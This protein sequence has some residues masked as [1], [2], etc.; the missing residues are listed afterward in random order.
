VLVLDAPVTL[1]KGGLAVS[2]GGH[3]IPAGSKGNVPALDVN[4]I[5]CFPN[6]ITGSA[7]HVQ[8]TGFAGGRDAQ[9]YTYVQQSD[10]NNAASQLENSLKSAAQAAIQ[11]QIKISEQLAGS[12]SCG[13]SSL[14][15]NQQAGDRVPYVT[16]SITETCW[17]EVYSTQT[18]QAL[19]ANLLKQNLSTLAGPRYII[20]GNVTTQV[21]T[22]PEQIDAQGT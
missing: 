20:V 18:G 1:R 4:G 14:S 7:Y 5:Y 11:V 6:C 17:S 10:I 19:A 16:V 9:S 8:N 3:V 2:A 12:I 15:S 13:L 21:L 22:P